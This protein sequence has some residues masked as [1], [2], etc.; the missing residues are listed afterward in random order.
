VFEIG[1]W[2][3][4]TSRGWKRLEFVASET[5][6]FYDDTAVKAAMSMLDWRKKKMALFKFR[7]ENDLERI[8][9]DY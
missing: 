7:N 8:V 4:R 6:A 1:L 2:Q 3:Y 9:V 5:N